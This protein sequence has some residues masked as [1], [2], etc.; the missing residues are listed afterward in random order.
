MSE[1]RY[2]CS[3]STENPE[4]VQY[5]NQF[6]AELLQMGKKIDC[7]LEGVQKYPDE[8]ILQIYATIFYLYGQTIQTQ[9]K[10]AEHLDKASK[11]LDQANEREKSLYSFAWH[12]LN[13]LLAEALKKIERHCFKWPKDLTA[14]KITEFLFY[15]KGQKYESHRFLRLTSHCYQEHKNN[16]F[17][18]AIHSFALELSTKYDE[19]MKTA[20]RALLLNEANPWAHHTLS[21]LFINK[22]FIDEGINILEHYSKLWS[23]FNHVIESHNLWHLALLYL[24]NLDFEKIRGIYQRANW[25][26]QAQ[27]VGEEI[28]ATALLWRLDM[29]GQDHATDWKALADSI[30][31]HANF[32]GTPFISAQ[33]IYALKKGNR[34][35]ALQ[36]ALVN[37]E[38]FAHEQFKEDR[39]VWRE[40]GLPLIHGSLAFADQDYGQALHYFDPIMEKVGCV[41]GSDAQ[42]D[43]FYQTYLKSLIGAQ[44]FWDAEHLLHKMTQGRDMTKLERKWLAECHHS[45][46]S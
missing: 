34:D 23:Q 31:D 29:E 3:L 21:H 42:I 45:S 37:I 38:N 6:S 40:V 44:R 10:A 4:V 12:W 13:Q 9:E 33:L 14:I 24:E 8:V 43:L 17:F 46:T 15:C 19:S 32:G 20:E 36:K 39:F 2:G 11:L 41:G 26:H 30:E 35:E 16:P 27:L 7:I 22:G 28:D 18:L 1:D 25:I 5:V